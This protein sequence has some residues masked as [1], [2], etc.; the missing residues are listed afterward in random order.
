LC[1]DR[2]VVPN[3]LKDQ[4]AFFCRFKQSEAAQNPEDEGTT[5]LQSIGK[6]SPKDTASHPKRLASFK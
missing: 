2:P 5:I 1:G 3:V 4:S 6:Y